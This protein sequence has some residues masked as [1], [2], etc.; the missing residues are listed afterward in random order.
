MTEPRESIDV[1]LARLRRKTEVTPTAEQV[2]AWHQRLAR[3]QRVTWKSWGLLAGVGALA[4]MGLLFFGQTLTRETPAEPPSAVGE[5]KAAPAVAEDQV[6]DTVLDDVVHEA[7]TPP[8]LSP[9]TGGAKLTEKE[10]IPTPNLIAPQKVSIRREVPALVLQF[11]EHPLEVPGSPTCPAWSAVVLHALAEQAPYRSL[12]R[13]AVRVGSLEW[14]QPQDGALVAAML[15]YVDKEGLPSSWLKAVQTANRAG[16]SIDVQKFSLLLEGKAEAGKQTAVSGKYVGLGRDRR[17]VVLETGKARIEVTGIEDIG[18]L[19]PGELVVVRGVGAPGPDAGALVPLLNA[20][21]FREG[22][23]AVSLLEAA[24]R[25]VNATN[26]P[27]SGVAIAPVAVPTLNAAILPPSSE[28]KSVEISGLWLSTFKPTVKAKDITFTEDGSTATATVE[29]ATLEAVNMK[30]AAVNKKPNEYLHE[31]ILEVNKYPRATLA[32]AQ[33][34]LSPPTAEKQTVTGELSFHGVMRPVEV[35]YSGNCTDGHCAVKAHFKFKF[36][37]FGIPE[38]RYMGVDL[39]PE[40]E[41]S[42]DFGVAQ[43][44]VFEA[45]PAKDE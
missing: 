10:P 5:L 12:G 4:A 19:T 26:V 8:R 11:L 7:P 21:V 15:D 45:R 38:I 16:A 9:E 30:Q 20:K 41:V 13:S 14:V 40:L 35:T 34:S 37:D 36:K 2:V 39:K 32:I 33:S 42:A 1:M 43:G 44:R 27:G 29:L 25:C 6:N 31:K 22:A 24:S 28:R 3:A 18:R 17:T 23:P